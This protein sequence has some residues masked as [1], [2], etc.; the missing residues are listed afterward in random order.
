MAYTKIK[1]IKSGTHL[2]E[3]LA[4]IQNPQKTD[5][6]LYIF[7][8]ECSAENACS[9]F[10]TVR[11]FAI[12]RGNNIAHHLVQS[13]SP[14]D[15]I[16]SQQA[17][18][19][20]IELMKRIYPDYQYVL[21]VH[22]DKGH[23]HNHIII[24]SVDCVNYKKLHSNRESLGEIR[25]ISDELCTENGLSVITPTPKTHR[26]K[27]KENIDAAIKNATSF[28]EFIFQ[29]KSQGYK[30]KF[31]EHI[32]FKGADDKRFIRADSIGSAYTEN[33]LMA[34]VSGEKLGNKKRMIYDDKSVYISQ[35]KR[36]R[37]I[38]DRGID[39]CN[40]FDE[41]LNYMRNENYEIKQGKHIA[42]KHKTG[43]RFIRAVSLGEDY[44]E[45]MLKLRIKD[46]EQFNAIKVKRIDK[47]IVSEKHL[48]NRT[49]DSK[50]VNAKIKTLNYL[51]DN[52]I[53]SYEELAERVETARKADSTEL[54]K[55]EILKWNV[56]HIEECCKLK[57]DKGNI[58]TCA[59]G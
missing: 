28:D 29:M 21:A 48:K 7:S 57:A 9:E 58:E 25:K 45:E 1:P 8:K 46:R 5:S 42:F 53:G 54:K 24:N 4:Y 30:V 19:I 56:E 40:S 36:L 39:K 13:F 32:A 51:N 59:R 37:L 17:A 6:K 22:T 11:N 31:G 52:G 14:D 44:T 10:E 38:I 27:L 41:F 35:R 16:T 33:S 3:V 47:L 2:S 18:E 23:I 55:L 49:I 43:Q 26:Q 34:R 50:N 20:G 12:K 15:N